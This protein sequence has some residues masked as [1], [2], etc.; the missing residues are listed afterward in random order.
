MSESAD[1]I[2]FSCYIWNVD[3]TLQLASDI[4]KIRPDTIIVLG[5]P[6]VSY[7]VFELMNANPAI[8]Y[9]VKGEGEATFRRLL[10][11]LSSARATLSAGEIGGLFCRDGVDIV[12]APQCGSYLE[13]DSLPSPF[14]AGL[15]DMGKPL[16]YYETSRGCPFSC[17]F[18][19]SSVEGK[20]R[21][22]CRERIESDLLWLMER[23]TRQVKL[24]D[25]TFNFDAQRANRIWQFILDHNRTSHFHF[26]IAADLL[27]DEN[28]LLLQS[29]PPDTFR[30]EIGVQ[31]TSED[32]LAQ[33]QRKADLQ[34][35]LANVRRLRSETF[36][37]L[38]LDLVAGLPGEGYQGLLDSLQ[39]LA[40]VNPHVIQIEPLKVLKGTAMREIAARE[41][42]AHSE[43][44][45]YAILHT[46][47]L[48][49]DEICRIE[50][51]GRLLD[52]FYNNGG[53]VAALRF[54]A[55]QTNFSA[56]LDGMARRAGSESLA[57]RTTKRLYELFALL[58]GSLL[59]GDR[60]RGQL[61]DALFFDYC[62]CE[63]PL[64]GRLPEFVA[65]RQQDC[66]W[67]GRRDLPEGLDLPVDSRIKAFRFS[68]EQDYRPEVWTKENCEITFVY[69]SGEGRG[70]R[71][72]TV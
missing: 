24:V 43:T 14:A 18:C 9:V 60:E 25:R 15:V 5:G 66:N 51:I 59:P 72:M 36:I 23:N 22:F 68:F 69:T 53:F 63:M 39:Q 45:P 35:I 38:H 34:K 6:E 4:K 41:G 52:L 47:W 26:E 49:Y 30:F 10:E 19:L 67:P 33:V 29:V 55:G 40:D 42:Y 71:V 13:L 46:P 31:S 21:S 28:M 7:S 44:A 58:A 62:C 64:A 16:I 27:T 2:A 32:T 61:H 65:T 8:D 37:E 12:A 50:T 48:T 1:V 57:G 54:M 17:A 56:L 70:L 11:M 20:V 3:M